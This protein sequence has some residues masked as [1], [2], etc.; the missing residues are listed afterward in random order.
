MSGLLVGLVDD[1]GLGHVVVGRRRRPGPGVTG[2]SLLLRVG[3]EPLREVL[4]GRGEALVGPG[5]RVDVG[6][7]DGAYVQRSARLDPDVLF[8]GVDVKRDTPAVMKTYLGNKGIDASRIEVVSYGEERPVAMGHDEDA[9]FQNRRAEFEATA[10][11]TNLLVGVFDPS[12]TEPMAS[13]LGQ[14]GA[15]AAYVVHGAGGTDELSLTGPNRVSHLHEGSV[16]T[17]E[18]DAQ[19]LGLARAGIDELIGGTAEEEAAGAIDH[20]GP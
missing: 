13:V 11:A 8:V 20:G 17:Y 4:Q 6:T 3:I 1:L 5:D 18:F 19:E 15:R 14:M 9:W 7:G 12:L 16:R 2:G 10:G